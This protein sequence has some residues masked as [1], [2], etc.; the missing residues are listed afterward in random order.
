MCVCCLLQSTVS[1]NTSNGETSSSE[2]MCSTSDVEEALKKKD[3]ELKELQ[4]SSYL[5]RNLEIG[6]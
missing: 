1:N 5:T 6:F 4:V 2:E 3:T